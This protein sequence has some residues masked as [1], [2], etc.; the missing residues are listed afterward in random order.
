MLVAGNLVLDL[1]AW[2]VTELRWDGTI[3]V[4]EFA[5]SVGGNGANT[6][7][8][9]AKMGVEVMLAGAV[10]KD[11]EGTELLGL[12]ED[13][14]VETSGVKRLALPTPTTLAM[15]KKTGERAFV[16]RPGAS[17]GALTKALRMPKAEHFHVANPFGV[18][19]LR[20]L[21]PENL[22]RAKKAGMTTS[23]DAGWDSRGEWGSVVL[24]CLEWVDVLFVNEEEAMLISGAKSWQAAIPLLPAKRVVLKRGKQGAV[25]DGVAVPGYTVAAMDSTGAGDVFAG[26]WIAASLRGQPPVAATQFAN[27]AAALSVTKLGSIAGVR[28]FRQTAQWMQAQHRSSLQPA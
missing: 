6:S 18:P 9:L 23:L 28:S 15:V 11:A 17:R 1:L 19:A 8:T 20:T 7:Y 24:P 2:P 22:R 25:V 5:R 14:G 12:L 10:G 27:A 16:H 21:A 3:W 4:D 13:V 26:A